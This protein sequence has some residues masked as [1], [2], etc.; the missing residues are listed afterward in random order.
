MCTLALTYI[1]S[2]MQ[3]IAERKNKMDYFDFKKLVLL[4]GL[5]IL[6]FS[7]QI[8]ELNRVDMFIIILQLINLT[9]KPYLGLFFIVR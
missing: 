4:C 2:P 3:D 1:L 7:P 6:P 8:N 5:V 9:D